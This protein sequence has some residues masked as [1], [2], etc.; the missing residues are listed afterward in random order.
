MFKKRYIKIFRT[1][2]ESR[3]VNFFRGLGEALGDN[4]EPGSLAFFWGRFP[5]KVGIIFSGGR[6]ELQSS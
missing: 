4:G 3:K 1:S 6:G 2:G 5:E